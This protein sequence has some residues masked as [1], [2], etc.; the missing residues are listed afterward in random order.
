MKLTS[1]FSPLAF[2]AVTL[3]ASSMISDAPADERRRS[4]NHYYTY[5]SRGRK[6]E[7]VRERSDSERRD[8]ER[9]GYNRRYEHSGYRERYDSSSDRERR[10]RG[11]DYNRE[12]ALRLFAEALRRR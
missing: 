8:R 11:H 7:V 5:D 4:H 6:I 9:R 1:S 3:T 12:Q 2:L 10:H